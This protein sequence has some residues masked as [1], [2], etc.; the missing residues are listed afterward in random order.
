MLHKFYHAHFSAAADL[1]RYVRVTTLAVMLILL[2]ALPLHAR[3]KKNNPPEFLHSDFSQLGIEEIYVTPAVDHRSDKDFE[4]KFQKPL[5]KGIRT[6]LKKRNYI[7]HLPEWEATI[8][9][10]E[11][12]VA[13]PSPALI[14]SL[15]PPG[16]EW[17]LLPVLLQFERHVNIA[18]K[19]IASVRLYLFQVQTGDLIWQGSGDATVK[20]GV[21]LT[22][23]AGHDAALFAALEAGA[24]FPEKEK[25]KG[26]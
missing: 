19:G 23:A 22:A 25:K 21:F 9:V 15:A 1:R 11:E 5:L 20:V 17:I 8:E 2:F 4:G 3:K 13:H 7:A 14:K 26:R 24:S 6:M 12:Q 18:A 16:A 10:T